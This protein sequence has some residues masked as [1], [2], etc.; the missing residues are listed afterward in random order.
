MGAKFLLRDPFTNP[1]IRSSI[2]QALQRL[3][4]KETVKLYWL[5]GQEHEINCQTLQPVDKNTQVMAVLAQFETELGQKDP[6]TLQ[7]LTQEF[8]L[9]MA[10]CYPLID[11]VVTNANIWVEVAIKRTTQAN[12]QADP[13]TSKIIKWQDKLALLSQELLQNTVN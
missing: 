1:L 10:F 2:L 9:Q 6:I 8:Q 4:F 7:I 5:D 13:S 12:L 11:Q 3:N